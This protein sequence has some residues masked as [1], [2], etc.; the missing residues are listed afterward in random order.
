MVPHWV[1]AAV[2]LEIAAIAAVV[3]VGIR[4][5]GEGAQAVG[6]VISWARPLSGLGGSPPAVVQP[7]LLPS[8]S[9]APSRAPTTVTA[10][11]FG[12][13][14]NG[15]TADVVFGQIRIL[16]EIR[17]ALRRYIEARAHGVGA[18]G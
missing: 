6:G 11:G 12:G 16:T 15:S 1:K 2:L 17:E 18:G 8:P 7:P 9:A 3:V 4:V 14:L 13:A 5:A 10:G